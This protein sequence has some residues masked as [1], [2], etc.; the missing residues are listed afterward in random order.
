MLFFFWLLLLAFVLSPAA[1]EALAQSRTQLWEYGQTAYL[2]DVHAKM[3]K[4]FTDPPYNETMKWWALNSENRVIF[5]YVS[6]DGNW[7]V[8]RMR[9]DGLSCIVDAGTDWQIMIPTTESSHDR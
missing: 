2:C 8:L 6:D 3:E 5:G 7:T 9:P 4:Q 1:L